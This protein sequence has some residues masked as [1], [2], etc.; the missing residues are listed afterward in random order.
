[1]DTGPTLLKTL[2]TQR[3]L[4]RYETFRAE[5]ERVATSLAPE[6]RYTAPSRAQYYRWLTGQLKGGTPYPDACR[7]LEGMFP[8]WTASDL[9]GPPL[10]GDEAAVDGLLASVPQSFPA[11]VLEGAWVTAYTFSQPTKAHADVAHITVEGERQVRARNYPPE[12]RTEGH[13]VAFRNEIDAQLV[14]RHLIGCWKNS[15]DTRYFG[16]LHLAV[17]PGETVMEGWYSGYD[18]DV[19]VAIG[20]WKWVRLDPT[21]LLGEG[22]AGVTLREP[23]AL[24]ELIEQY[25]QYDAPLPLAAVV[26]EPR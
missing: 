26:E 12:P 16:S 8:P 4:Q 6:L 14:N 2:L 22:L 7:V 23:R 10:P 9:F 20:H 25:T 15:S 5:Y 24:R 19:A 1:V 21:S 18:S 3:H 13:G 17:L 11:G